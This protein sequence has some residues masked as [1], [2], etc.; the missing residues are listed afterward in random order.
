MWN[1][2]KTELMK[3]A[4]LMAVLMMAVFT[5]V[6]LDAEY[7]YVGAASGLTSPSEAVNAQNYILG[8]SAAGYF[9]YPL[10]DRMKGKL[11]RMISLVVS[12]AVS[13][14]CIFMIRQSVTYTSALLFG[15]L[16][17]LLLG[18]FSGKVFDTAAGTIGDSPCL[19]TMAG[20]S[21]AFGIL[22]QFINNNLIDVEPAE[23]I[24]LSISLIILALSFIKTEQG[25]IDAMPNSGKEQGCTEGAL[26]AGLLLAL[27]IALMACVFS[28]LDNEVTLQHVSGTNIGQWPRLLLAASGIV[29]GILFDLERRTYMPVMMY[30]VMLLSVLC[31]VL[32][33]FGI[34]FM[35][36]LFIFYLSSGFFVVFFTTSFMELSRHLRFSAMWAGMG[37]TA[38]NITAVLIT[39]FSISLLT[40]ENHLA[41]IISA[42]AFFMAVSVVMFVYS[43]VRDSALKNGLP[44]EDVKNSQCD[45]SQRFAAAFSL[46]PREYEVFEHL[47]STE[48]SVQEMADA[49]YM[50]RRTLQ[51]NIA[52]IYEKT[53]TKSRLGLYRLYVEYAAKLTN[54]E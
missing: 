25:R 2:I 1:E 3:P 18:V 22:L 30:C 43:S 51:R 54:G 50:S 20:F 42:L 16:L 45:C 15:I 27:L 21:Y 9:M 10:L 53:G 6:F 19:A 23:S 13:V 47:T 12:T 35:G 17:F 5:F 52:S 24:V 37:R 44:E 36:G 7:M 11:F 8:I 38:N 4:S 46:T 28:T 40:A 29:A 48:E 34:P 26:N 33:A 41:A 31:I 14:V 32:P 49:L 39:R